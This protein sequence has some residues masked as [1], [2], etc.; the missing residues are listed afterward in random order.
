MIVTTVSDD[1]DAWAKLYGLCES[2]EVA[3][4]PGGRIATWTGNIPGRGLVTIT[5]DVSHREGSALTSFNLM[6]DRLAS[7]VSDEMLGRRHPEEARYPESP[8]TIGAA[9]LPE[10]RRI[11]GGSFVVGA[12]LG[13]VGHAL[14][15]RIGAPS[16][17]GGSASSD[18]PRALASP[19]R[20]CLTG[21]A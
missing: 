17:R 15:S 13:A 16:R 5:S 2:G 12:L 18:A 9:P 19:I 4:A 3:F 20:C 8:C 11:D 1:A 10:Q 7:C 21:A 14:L 6:L